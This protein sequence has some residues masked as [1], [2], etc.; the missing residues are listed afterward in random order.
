MTW[1]REFGRQVSV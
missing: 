1:N